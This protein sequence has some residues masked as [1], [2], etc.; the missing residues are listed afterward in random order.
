MYNSE[1][2][3]TLASMLLRGRNA[4]QSGH[5]D[6]NKAAMSKTIDLLAM[7][8]GAGSDTTSASLQTFFKV[9]AL[10]PGAM[11]RAQ[12]GLAYPKSALL[13]N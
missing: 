3:N 4:E 6:R 9:M 7:L 1:A 8:L 13:C 2:S 11:K 5:D 12:Q 10:F